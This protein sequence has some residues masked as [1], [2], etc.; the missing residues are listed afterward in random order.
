[1]KAWL[2]MGV[3]VALTS[4]AAAQQDARERYKYDLKSLKD[5]LKS[6]PAAR[7]VDKAPLGPP[8]WCGPLKEAPY[9]AGLGGHMDSYYQQPDQLW[10]LAGA[11]GAICKNDPKEPLIQ[12][13][14][15]EILQVWMNKFGLNAKDAVESLKLVL[16]DP[17]SDAGKKRV[18]GALTISDEIEGAEKIFMQA[19][20]TLFD[21]GGSSLNATGASPM[22]K[23]VPWLDSSAKQPDEMVRLAFVFFETEMIATANESFFEKALMAYPVGQMDYKSLDANK[24]LALLPPRDRAVQGERLRS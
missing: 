13:F 2:V 4:E 3:V 8:G 20:R 6:T 19:R 23:M 24:V 5:S 14:A 1:M 7:G 9:G 17:A 22:V 18:C 15:Q 11:V 12:K 16:D 10:K 21:C